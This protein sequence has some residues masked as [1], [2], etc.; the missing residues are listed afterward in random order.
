M[1]LNRRNIVLLVVAALLALLAPAGAA[2]EADTPAKV[3]NPSSLSYCWR[4]LPPLG[5]RQA[6]PMD[7]LPLNYYRRSVPSLVSDAWA[8]TGNL[9]AEGLNMIF[10]ERPAMSDFFFADALRPW[11]NTIDK[12]RFYNTRIPMTLV[13]FN[14]SGG[15]DNA[16]ERLQTVFSGNINRRAQVGALL[17][18]LYSKGSYQNQ[19]VK[20]LTWGLSGSY[21]GDRYELQA[22]YN[23]F[24]MLNKENGGITD[25]LYITDPAELQ[26][27]ISTIDPKSIPVFLANAHNRLWGQE[28]FVNN[29]YKVGYWHEETKEGDTTVTR[30]YIPVFSFIYTLQY[31]ADKHLFIDYNKSDTR[32]FFEHTYLDPDKTRDRTTRWQISNTLGVSML[33]GF[34]KYAKFGLAGYI[35]HQVRRYNLTP[36]TLDRTTLDLSPFPDGIG[37][38]TPHVTQ[39]LVWVGGQITKQ[40]GSLL[41]YS[42][43]ARFGLIGPVAGDI[44]LEGRVN[45]KFAFLRDSVDIAAFGSFK[46]E[47]AP[48]LMNNYLSNH[49]IWQNHFGKRRTMSFGGT[50]D[51]GRSGTSFTAK[52]SNLQNHI[53]FAPDDLPRQHGGSVQVLSLAL[54][55]N[56]RAGIFHWDNS[57][58]YQTTSNDAVIPLPALAVYSNMYI[59][60][61]I[62]TL[63]VQLGLDCDYYTSYYAPL[64]Q[65]ATMAFSNQREFKVGNYPFCNVYAN[66]KL[67]RTRFYVMYSHFNKGLFGG[68]GYFSMPYYPLNPSRLQIGLCVDFAN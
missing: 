42:A 43:D 23:H 52:L 26:G 27:G 51:I 48:Y 6:E 39:Q 66:M 8:T 44:S 19:A 15:R 63:N 46:N 18:Y 55:Q 49:F 34:H 1:I 12:M 13:A 32:E 11:M 21:M 17:D 53:Y 2:Q 45:T 56:I 36:D 58:T 14:S 25:M 37:A 30:T 29:R 60:F 5:L 47:E 35:T 64:Y 50:I 4:V 68:S 31:N 3:V 24:N 54:K 40:R 7:T 67:S 38:F 22:Y 41:T 9:G 61:N 20:Q 65:P 59:L 10:S 16:Q 33:E 62:A 57:I 28:L